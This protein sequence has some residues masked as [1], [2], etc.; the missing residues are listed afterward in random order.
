MVGFFAHCLGLRSKAIV[1]ISVL[2]F[3]GVKSDR[4]NAGPFFVGSGLAIFSVLVTFAFI[5]PLTADGMARE[6]ADV[7]IY[8][9]QRLSS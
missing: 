4:G 9:R 5:R 2:A 6:D 7:C 1:V 3:G 8:R